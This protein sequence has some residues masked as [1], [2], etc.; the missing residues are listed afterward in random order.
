VPIVLKSGSL[1]LLEP[2]GPVKACNGIALP[3]TAIIKLHSYTL[4]IDS[5]D[6]LIYRCVYPEKKK[7]MC[8]QGDSRGKDNIFGGDIIGHREKKF[9]MAMPLIYYCNRVRTV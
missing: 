2:S 7:G 6:F 3:F 9:Y 5:I 1:N 4:I 8:I